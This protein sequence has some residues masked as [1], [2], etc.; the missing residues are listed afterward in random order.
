MH[1]D[2]MPSKGSN[3]A[4]LLII[5]LSERLYSSKDPI[6]CHIEASSLAID[7]QNPKAPRSALPLVETL[8][9]Y[10]RRVA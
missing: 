4:A 8:G 3:S 7:I 5:S 2:S 1:L 9:H 6:D 10:R